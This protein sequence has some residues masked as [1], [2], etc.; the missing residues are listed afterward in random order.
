MLTNLYA[1][2][3]SKA[4]VYNVPFAMINHGVALRASKDMANDPKSQT[5]KTPEDFT[6]FH[7]GT[8]D[9]E[10]AKITVL[11]KQDCIA[12]FIQLKEEQLPLPN[13]KEA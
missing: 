6:L 11:D 7:I 5:S 2:Y 12:K 10:F 1:I 9:D 8:Y 3:D 4:K 13:L